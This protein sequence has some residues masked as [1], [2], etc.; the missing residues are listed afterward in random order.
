MSFLLHAL[1]ETEVFLDVGANAGVY[2]VLASKV[3]GART[4][5]FEPIKSTYIKLLDQLR[6]NGIQELVTTCNMGV[7]AEKGELPFFNQND[8]LN[9]VSLGPQV[10][11]TEVITITTLDENT[12]SSINYFLKID[13][14]GFEYYVLEGANRLLSSENVLAIII[15]LNDNFSGSD[16]LIIKYIASSLVIA[17]YL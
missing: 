11:G 4:I 17:T 13:V 14:E 6:V 9:K 16:L 8:T 3:V 2:T 1:R 15:E 10:D 7:G 12:N 5:A